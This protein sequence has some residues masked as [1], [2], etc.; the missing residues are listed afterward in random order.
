MIR[1]WLAAALLATCMMA[2][3]RSQER[4]TRYDSTVLVQPDPAAG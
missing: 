1:A 2:P 4:I 3:A